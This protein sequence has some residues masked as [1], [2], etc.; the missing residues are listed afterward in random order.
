[1]ADPTYT[2]AGLQTEFNALISA[3]EAQSWADARIKLIRCRAVIGG[4]P[5]NVQ[6][7]GATLSIRAQVDELASLIKAAEKESNQ[8]RTDRRIIRTRVSHG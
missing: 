7:D 8:A 2:L 5:S 3:V 6:T 1:M 4:L